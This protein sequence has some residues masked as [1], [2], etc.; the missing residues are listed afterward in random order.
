MM[1]SR[2]VAKAKMKPVMK[3]PTFKYGG[4]SYVVLAYAKI[5]KTPFTVENILG[6]TSK[7]SNSRDV[8]RAIEVL[9]K[10]GSIK[11]VTDTSWV[12]TPVGLQQVYDFASRRSVLAQD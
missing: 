6:F 5:K 10:N 7:I 3:A 2:H 11:K 12:V 1:P 8:G 4:S 9:L